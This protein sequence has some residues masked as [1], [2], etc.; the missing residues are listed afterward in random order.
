MRNADDTEGDKMK[1]ETVNMAT[2][3]T[4]IFNGGDMAN[5]PHWGTITC[6]YSDTWGT[7]VV[8]APEDDDLYPDGE[9]YTV[10][11]VMV[12]HVYK[13]HGGTRIVT[14]KAYD[15]WRAAQIAKFAKF[16]ARTQESA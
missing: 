4:R 8:I 9:T 10:P 7:H 6:I 14:E 2:E 15:A 11:L 1:T 3:G 13:G 12:Q 5:L 16:E